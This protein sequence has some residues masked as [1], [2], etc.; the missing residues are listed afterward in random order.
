MYSSRLS[1]LGEDRGLRPSGEPVADWALEVKS[2]SRSFRSPK[3]EDVTILGDVDFHVTRGSLVSVVGQS[4]AG[5]TTLMRCMAGLLP[6]TSGEVRVNGQAIAGPPPNLALILQDYS[7]SLLPWMKVA[8]NIAL[9]LRGQGVGKRER[10]RRAEEALEH[11]GL[12]GRGAQYPWQM[13]GGMQQRVSIARALAYEPDILLMD[14]P[15]ASVDAQ[16]REDL[17]DLTHTVHREYGMTIVL[18]T[19]D[20]EEAI[21]LADRV[22]V[23]RGSPSRVSKVYPVPLGNFRDQVST[24][25][26]PEFGDLR[27][28]IRNDIR[29]G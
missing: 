6:A 3:G 18:V 9:P 28:H 13:S 24:K 14:E 7:R 11:V 5:K 8:S 17:E 15:F 4:G 27:T 22:V 2:L 23:L 29:A 21:Y 1:G 16:T 19:H 20:I 10:M 26:M 12:A 25:V